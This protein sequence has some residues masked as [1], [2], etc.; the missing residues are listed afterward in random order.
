MDEIAAWPMHSGDFFTDSQSN[1][2]L[3]AQPQWRAAEGRMRAIQRRGLC[4]RWLA[5]IT[6]LK[7]QYSVRTPL[8]QAVEM[9]ADRD[10]IWCV[11]PGIPKTASAH[12]PTGGIEF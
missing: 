11:R 3:S 6:I 1:F 9:I 4:Q 5:P 2:G 7:M 12:E 8:L 10:G